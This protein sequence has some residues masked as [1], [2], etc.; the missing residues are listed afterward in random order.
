MRGPTSILAW[1]TTSQIEYV[2]TKKKKKG[3]RRCECEAICDDCAGE[4]SLLN[5]LNFNY[6]YGT[7]PL[8]L[9]LSG[10]SCG[11]YYVFY[12]R[13]HSSFSLKSSD[14]VPVASGASS[15][16]ELAIIEPNINF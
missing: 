3:V 4:V 13:G 11:H 1:F 12:S 5:F 9:Q 7:Q 10:A 15:G 6:K 8:Q 14:F 2:V 16:V